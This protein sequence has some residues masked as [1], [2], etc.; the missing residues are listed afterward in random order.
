M[1]EESA[2]LT[3]MR[4]HMIRELLKI[5]ASHLN[6]HP[7]QRLP[8][9]VNITFEYIEGEG[10]LLLLNM[11]G[12]CASTGSACNSA[13]LEPSH[14]LTAMG[15]PHEIAH[16]SVRLTLG[17]RNTEED[18]SYVLE[19]LPEVVGKLRSMSPLTPEE[20]R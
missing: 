12:I 6:G 20:L 7:T 13:S 2:R 17:E 10:I 18:V 11:F 4:D 3:A 15:V 1:P 16:G 19:K 8:N 9:N 5:P 14:V